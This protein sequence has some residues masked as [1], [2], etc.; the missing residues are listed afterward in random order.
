[1]HVVVGGRREAGAAGESGRGRRRRGRRCEEGPGR[2]C[3]AQGAQGVD[4]GG[5]ALPEEGP[6]H[7]RQMLR[8]G[9]APLL[10]RVL[11]QHGHARL[12]AVALRAP[13]RRL[14]HRP[15][16]TSPL[17]GLQRLLPGRAAHVDPRPRPRA[18]H[19]PRRAERHL[20]RRPHGHQPRQGH[21]LRHAR[22]PRARRS[23][24]RFRS[25]RRD[26]EGPPAGTTPAST[27]SRASSPRASRTSAT[28]RTTATTPSTSSSPRSPA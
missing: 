16:P 13:P 24:S 25:A 10:G 6:G 12:R 5:E 27:A 4:G 14:R 3:A 20:P 2:G 18:G 9:D 22:P 15:R 11:W 19:G 8:R 26:R 17:D 23:L 28:S 21:R 1:M 7:L